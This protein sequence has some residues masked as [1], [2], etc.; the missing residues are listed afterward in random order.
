MISVVKYIDINIVFIINHANHRISVLYPCIFGDFLF[1]IFAIIFSSETMKHALSYVIYCFPKH[2]HRI[3]KYNKNADI[4]KVI[5]FLFR[6]ICNL[7]NPL[8]IYPIEK[9]KK[10]KQT[11]TQTKTKTEKKSKQKEQ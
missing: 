3:A 2:L 7:K 9:N 8:K 6:K 1:S 4:K 11:N 5:Y 10:S